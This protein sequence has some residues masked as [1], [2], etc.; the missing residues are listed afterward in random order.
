MTNGSRFKT[1]FL[2][3]AILLIITLI[4]WLIPS[5]FLGSINGRI[6][7]LNLRTGLTEA[8]QQTLIDL[9]WSQIWWETQQATIF[10]PIAIIL[11]VIS[12]II[13]LYGVITK[14]QW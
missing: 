10:N 9:Q 12:V 6:D 5:I 11:L 3:G 4:I 1:F 7:L 14:F 13:M 2:V 8:E